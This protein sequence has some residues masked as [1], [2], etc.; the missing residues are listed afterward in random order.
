MR[1]LHGLGDV[2]RSSD[3]RYLK[4]DDFT[5]VTGP[6]ATLNAAAST[7]STYNIDGDSDFFWTKA[8]VFALSTDFDGTYFT[9][10]L[11]AVD[12]II[13][14]TTSGRQLM[15]SQVPITSVAGTGQIPFILPIERFFA[16]KST[17]KIDYFNVGDANITLLRLSF[18]GIKAFIAG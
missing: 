6:A 12:I 16:A 8:C 17:V 2:P 1:G 9:Q 18:I 5:Y 4:K 14:D 13:T 11:P 15:N 7:T 3:G 10:T